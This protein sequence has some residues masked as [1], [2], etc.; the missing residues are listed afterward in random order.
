MTASDIFL[1]IAI[2]CAVCG[3]AS[4]IAMADALQKRG[5]RVNWIL[6]RMFMPRYAVQYRDVIRAE[7]GRVGPWYYVFLGTINLALVTAVIGL[8]LRTR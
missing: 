5:V 2:V 4:A 7:T 8:I 1:T 3:V 6:M